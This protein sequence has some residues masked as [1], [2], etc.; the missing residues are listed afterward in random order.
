MSNEQIDQI[1]YWMELQEWK[2]A[3]YYLNLRAKAREL[4]LEDIDSSSD[5]IVIR[6]FEAIGRDRMEEIPGFSEIGLHRAFLL[7]LYRIFHQSPPKELF[8]IRRIWYKV[9]KQFTQQF[10]NRDVKERKTDYSK[11]LSVA[12]QSIVSSGIID[13]RDFFVE[14]VSRMITFQEQYGWKNIVLFGEKDAFTPLIT[15][16][17][18]I[19]GIKAVY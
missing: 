10:W 16:T 9:F 6:V 8:S 18:Q 12:L 1:P 5:N 2:F 3:D 11:K 7:D 13:Y 15:K 14:D 17:A 19:L 4:D